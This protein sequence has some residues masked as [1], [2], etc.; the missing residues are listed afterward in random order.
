MDFLVSNKVCTLSKSFTTLKTFIR[1]FSRV[2]S[3][4][5]NERGTLTESSPTDNPLIGLL[6]RVVPLVLEEV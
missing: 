6:S 4:V 3:L 1:F 5:F 2:S